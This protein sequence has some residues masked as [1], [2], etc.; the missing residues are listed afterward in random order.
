MCPRHDLMLDPMSTYVIP[1][2][3]LCAFLSST[4]SS[5]G[6][7]AFAPH[8]TSTLASGSAD[9]TVRV[10]SCVTGRCEAVLEGHCGDM[11]QVLFAPIRE[12]PVILTAS[13]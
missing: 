1:P 9:E 11:T 4:R 12:R 7:L 13:T 10:W 5:V 6:A 3:Y 8:G 2:P